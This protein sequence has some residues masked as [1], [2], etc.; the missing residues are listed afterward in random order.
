METIKS[1]LN[2]VA[3]NCYM[4]KIDINNPYYSIPILPEHQ[5]FFKFSLRGK[6]YKFT[7]LPKGLC[8]GSRK[9]TNQSLY[10]SRINN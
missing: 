3:P 5:K 6:L 7:C 1:V 10:D 4:A 9:F 8:S 2:L